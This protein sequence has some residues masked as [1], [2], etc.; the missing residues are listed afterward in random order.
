MY[1]F[2]FKIVLFG[3]IYVGILCFFF[4]DFIVQFLEQQVCFLNWDVGFVIQ[5]MNEIGV[6]LFRLLEV[7]DQLFKLWDL[8]WNRMKKLLYFLDCIYVLLI[9][10]VENFS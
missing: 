10:Y 5:I 2:S 1:V 9:R 4:L 7:Y 8:F 6:L 3:K